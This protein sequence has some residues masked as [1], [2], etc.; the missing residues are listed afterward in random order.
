MG[1]CDILNSLCGI[2]EISDRKKI[3]NWVSEFFTNP[4]KKCY[5]GISDFLV[6]LRVLN[7][8]LVT[9]KEKNVNR[10][11]YQPLFYNTRIK[12]AR[13]KNKK[14]RKAFSTPN[15]M[16]LPDNIKTRS[17]KIADF[18]IDDTIIKNDNQG[19][20][21]LAHLTG[22][23]KGDFINTDTF[24]KRLKGLFDP[25]EIVYNHILREANQEPFTS[26]KTTELFQKAKKGSKLFRKELSKNKK[27]K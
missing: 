18:V 7:K 3:L 4:I 6:S 12:F 14:T 2:E 20:T 11:L 13:G 15:D 27:K 8:N 22:I 1:W 19:K 5:L 24:C 16:G 26:A 21:I 9:P 10:W 17:L 23:S 25:G